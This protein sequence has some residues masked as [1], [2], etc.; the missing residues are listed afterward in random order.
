MSANRNVQ[1][2]GER[3]EILRLRMLLRRGLIFNE[4]ALP[5]LPALQP[6]AVAKG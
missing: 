1:S 3:A 6:S 2:R 4:Q 5:R